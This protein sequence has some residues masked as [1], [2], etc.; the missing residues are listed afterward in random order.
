MEPGLGGAS[1][2]ENHH[3][4]PDRRNAPAVVLPAN[5]RVHTGQIVILQAR[6]LL[7][8]PQVQP[9]ADHRAARIDEQ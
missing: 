1:L 5:E 8:L 7:G 3:P 9:Y 6:W 4:D 2:E